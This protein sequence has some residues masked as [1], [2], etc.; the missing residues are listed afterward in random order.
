MAHGL[1]ERRRRAVARSA[2]YGSL[3]VVGVGTLLAQ[4]YLHLPPTTREGEVGW[5]AVDWDQEAAVRLLQQY[6]RID[7][8]A[9]G[10]EYAAALF[11]AAPLE[12]AG[13]PVHVERVGPRHANLWAILEGE[14]PDALVLLNHL[15]VEP[16]SA[17]GEWE[18]PPFAGVLEP[19]WLHGRGA[20]DMKS[21]TV[22]QLLALLELRARH[23]RPERTVVF[24]ATSSEERG[25]DLGLRWVVREHPE[26]VE[27]FWA[28]LTEGGIVEA[29]SLDSIK[30]WGIEVGQRRYPQL[31]ACAP[32]RQRLDELRA[33]LRD[34][35]EP[36]AGIEV[37]PEI[38]RFWQTYAATRDRAELRELIGDPDG[39][40]ADP[41]R[42]VELP[43]YLRRMLRNEVV[44]G[45]PAPA[46]GGGWQMR[47]TFFL[48]PSA[49][50]ETVRRERLPDWMT[51]GVGLVEKV[52][53][54]P[55]A[56]SPLEHPVMAAIEQALVA[57]Q[58]PV[59]RGPFF[60]P[61]TATDA[62]FLRPLGIPAYG[63]SPFLILSPD[64]LRA[65]LPNERIAVPGLV[66][67]AALYADVVER[68]AAAP[69]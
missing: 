3:V 17:G 64:T 11:L 34:F 50:F 39:L 45:P 1:V 49:D 54:L 24:L 60:L 25:S 62:R 61:A 37:D 35:D 41:A 5:Y 43:L 42:F 66:Q 22:A 15:D 38:R 53:P 63:F 40:R 9:E 29:R 20:F 18:H 4:R 30:Y 12:A 33:D 23:P 8:S 19:P 67:G 55:A 52:A 27:R 58:G 57:Q 44:A 31:L 16:A 14:D 28:V 36:A 51:A 56:I 21:V 65:G 48:L 10:D 47:I 7:S 69:R 26:L 32:T 46:P 59:P 2:L 13:I 6:I 68:L